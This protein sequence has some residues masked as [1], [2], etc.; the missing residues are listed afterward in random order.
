MPLP[1]TTFRSPWTSIAIHSS[2]FTQ[3]PFHVLEQAA[4][5]YLGKFSVWETGQRRC[6]HRQLFAAGTSISR[7]YIPSHNSFLCEN[8]GRQTCRQ[9]ANKDM[10]T[11][12]GKWTAQMLQIIVPKNYTVEISSTTNQVWRKSIWSTSQNTVKQKN[13]STTVEMPSTTNRV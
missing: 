2:K 7:Q 4:I 1:T 9:P 12:P 8:P 13:C 11:E 10:D 6:F 5:Q 3:H